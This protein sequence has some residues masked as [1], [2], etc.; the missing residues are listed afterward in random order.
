MNNK[1]QNVDYTQ[2][3]I[4]S[5]LLFNAVKPRDME[6][7]MA[8]LLRKVL[9]K[10]YLVAI[11]D[12]VLSY[13]IP[14]DTI[15]SDL[16][17][18]NAWMKANILKRTMKIGIA[19]CN[20]IENLI[21]TSEVRVIGE[22]LTYMDDKKRVRTL[23]NIRGFHII[24][25]THTG[26]VIAAAFVADAV[27]YYAKSDGNGSVLP[28]ITNEVAKGLGMMNLD[29]RN[30]R[31]VLSG[32]TKSPSV[33]R[34]VIYKYMEI[35]PD[36]AF[37]ACNAL[38]E[39]HPDF[40]GRSEVS[41]AYYK[42]CRK[43][44][45]KLPDLAAILLP[46]PGKPPKCLVKMELD[47]MYRFLADCRGVRGE[48]GGVGQVTLGYLFGSC[49]RSMLKNITLFL[50]IRQVCREGNVRV[51]LIVGSIPEFVKR[52]LVAN[53]MFVLDSSS[54]NNQAL[55]KS[56]FDKKIYGVYAYVS[57]KITY[58]VW[59]TASS[60]S[61]EVIERVVKFENV[62]IGPLFNGHEIASQ[63]A[64]HAV[65]VHMCPYM[66][67][68]N[69]K[70]GLLP[71]ALPH[72]GLVIVTS[73]S[74]RG[75]KVEDLIARCTAANHHRNNWIITRRSFI[76]ADALSAQ[77][78]YY[79]EYVIPKMITRAKKEIVSWADYFVSVK[80]ER[81]KIAVEDVQI[82]P[83]LIRPMPDVN[84]D[85][86][87]EELIA[88]LRS[89]G[90][91]SDG[92]VTMFKQWGED[93]QNPH[94]RFLHG[95]GIEEPQLIKTLTERAPSMKDG[96]QSGYD[97]LVDFRVAQANLV[98]KRSQAEPEEQ[99]TLSNPIDRVPTKNYSNIS[100]KEDDDDNLEDLFDV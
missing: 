19:P 13:P 64:F 66:T 79:N 76:C 62:S 67:G 99:E 33:A 93:A 14:A 89:S 83:R 98:K 52:M 59:Y 7:S 41:L 43:K 10:K 29:T 24:E 56:L 32:N 97:K 53:E 17:P 47:A 35:N 8:S 37:M 84:F 55:T 48:D 87:I 31:R 72:N 60:K 23:K 58:G 21:T 49:T 38:C 2:N 18:A 15:A 95:R 90:T 85:S 45:D 16:P 12:W 50:D 78:G 77:V 70:H 75:V 82:D 61:P 27:T 26:P 20:T 74:F 4:A 65:R 36:Q 11:P 5:D 6:D 63:V 1:I 57:D 39:A 9:D 91:P 30:M 69:F 96:I 22:T 68:K 94:M 28:T 100:I 54:V 34:D 51:I 44:D 3:R 73:V 42:E 86:S 40:A 46:T 88:V 25:E 92:I 81:E 71:C 80:E